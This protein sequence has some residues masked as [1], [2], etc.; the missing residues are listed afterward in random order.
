[1]VSS[2]DIS[3]HNFPVPNLDSVP[4]SAGTLTYGVTWPHSNS[5]CASTSWCLLLILILPRNELVGAKL[6][7]QHVV[8]NHTVHL[9]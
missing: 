2:R 9:I 8:W 3:Q 5:N 6:M 7:P 1:M 4:A